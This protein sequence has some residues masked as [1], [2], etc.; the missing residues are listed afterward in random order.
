MREWNY[1]SYLEI[2]RSFWHQYMSSYHPYLSAF[3]SFWYRYIPDHLLQFMNLRVCWMT[4][5]MESSRIGISKDFDW[6][7][8]KGLLSKLS[9]LELQAVFASWISCFL[10]KQTTFPWV[11]RVLPRELLV[12]V[13]VTPVSILACTHFSPC[14][15][16]LLIA[17]YNCFQWFGDNITPRGLLP[18]SFYPKAIASIDRDCTTLS[19]SHDSDLSP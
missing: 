16:D 7:W 6:V 10:S 4:A 11:D 9:S 3:E 18:H 19:A 14:I 2:R 13:D 17:T 8:H 15:D 5:N 12:N 1:F